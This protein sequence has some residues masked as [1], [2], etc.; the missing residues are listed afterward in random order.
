MASKTP[1]ESSLR[2]NAI[3]ARSTRSPVSYTPFWIAALVSVD[4]VM[5]VLAA[6]IGG[7]LVDHRWDVSGASFRLRHSSI[8]FVAVW[9]GMFCWLGL[10]RRTLALSFKDEFYFTLIALIFGVTPQLVLFTLIPDLSTSRLV[11]LLSALTAVGL[12]GTS[13]S[14]I[15]VVR[16]AAEKRRPI[17]ILLIGHSEKL[18]EVRGHLQRDNSANLEVLTLDIGLIN[19]DKASTDDKVRFLLDTASNWKCDR[20]ILVEPDDQKIQRQLLLQA[21]A[22]GVKIAAAL[23]DLNLGTY[24]ALIERE[25]HQSLLVTVQPKICHPTARLVK[26]IFDVVSAS[27]ILVACSPVLISAALLIALDSGRPIFF[28]QERV[29]RDGR[30]FMILK[31]RTMKHDADS[32]WAKPGDSR[33][34]RFGRFL[35]RTSIDE[36][37]QLINVLRGD[38]SLVGPRP[39]MRVFEEKFASAIPSYSDRRLALPGITGWAQVSLKR[40][41]TPDD[42]DQ[43]LSYD[44]FYIEHWSFFLDLTVVLKT[45]AEFLFHRAA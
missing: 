20:V 40:N 26:R 33:V 19:L 43:V 39:E 31:L 23:P 16:V 14:L 12:V 9:V 10:Y 11:L 15:H 17:R 42:A 21:G 44:L 45:A 28:Q 6:Y 30:V 36:L 8:I 25:G 3:G 32:E 1:D 38:M 27:L 24:D 5:F 18:S 4:L 29:G 22:A 41:L 13:R 7:A 35:R 37:P 34:T 2:F